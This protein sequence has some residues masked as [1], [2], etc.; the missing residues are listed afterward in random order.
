MGAD[1]FCTDAF[2]GERINS[3]TEQADKLVKLKEFLT[4]LSPQL[5]CYFNRVKR[6]RSEF[7]A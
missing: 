5:I 2:S 6:L 7:I 4:R 3:I 1:T